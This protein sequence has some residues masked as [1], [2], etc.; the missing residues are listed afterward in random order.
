[1]NEKWN[2]F[3]PEFSFPFNL[4]PALKVE[5]VLFPHD[6]ER[7]RSFGTRSTLWIFSWYLRPFK[8]YITLVRSP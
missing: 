1:M 3:G 4:A 2:L 5:E 6:D 8:N 7:H